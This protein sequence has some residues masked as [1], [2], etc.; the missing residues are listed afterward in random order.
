MHSALRHFH[1]NRTFPV[2]KHP[3][4]LRRRKFLTER[5]FRKIDLLQYRP[6]FFHRGTLSKNP[7]NQF[8]L[9]NIVFIRFNFPVIRVSH[10]VQTGN[11]QSLFI[12]CIIIQWIIVCNM[13]H[14]DHCIVILHHSHTAKRKRIIPRRYCHLI[15]IGKLII[16]RTAKIQIFCLISC[17]CTHFVTSSYYPIICQAHCEHTVSFTILSMSLSFHTF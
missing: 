9:G 3:M 11:S 8:E 7:G 2:C 14:T 4:E 6:G 16:H 15:S 5:Y 13:S 12:H 1:R 17:C 10:K